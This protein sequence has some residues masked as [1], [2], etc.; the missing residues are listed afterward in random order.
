MSRKKLI[1]S[2]VVL[3]LAAA[4]AYLFFA[5]VPI[6]PG[7]WT[8]PAAPALT[9]QYQQNTRLS[10]TL[11]MS[12]GDSHK[13]EDIAFDAQ[14]RLYAGFEDGNIVQLEPDGSFRVFANTQGRPLGLVFDR[15]GNLIVADAIKGLLSISQDSE[16][17]VLATEADGVKFGC[18][19]DLDIGADGTI[20]FSEASSKYP[21]SEFASDIL[22]HQPNGRLMALDPQTQKPRTLLRGLYFANGVAVSPDQSFVLVAETGKY[23][24]RRFWLREPKQG[25][26]DTL[27]D[28]LPGFPDGISSNG[29]DKFWLALVTPRQALFDRLLPHPFLR[30]VVFRLP[31]ALQPAPERYS[32]VVALD[33]QGRVVEN[34]QNGGPYCYAQIA[35][36]IEHDGKLYFGSI[37][38]D[39][40]GQFSLQS[41][42][43]LHEKR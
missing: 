7:T 30:K 9:G 43:A 18:L 12:L 27:I 14:D 29:R 21:M 35:N 24:I 33:S 20:Y 25:M 34:L 41:G 10:N 23:R 28:N 37:G 38:E 17:K 3:I 42:R 13:P 32:F 16:I 26:D 15:T 11:R 5:P 1:A 31:K 4:L 8:P 2:F 39:S 22:E 6:T 40:V 36:V 19:N